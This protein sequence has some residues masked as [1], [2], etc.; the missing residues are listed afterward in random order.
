MRAVGVTE[1]GGPEALRLLDVPDE[2]LGK[3]QVRLRVTAAAVNPTD[4]YARNGT[5]ADRDP[6]DDRAHRPPGPGLDGAAARTGAR[7][8]RRCRRLRRVRGAA[9]PGRGA[10]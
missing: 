2:P 9:G 10:D 7:R 8:D 3:G 4:T 5:Y 6:P 1:F